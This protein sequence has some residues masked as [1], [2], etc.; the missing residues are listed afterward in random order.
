[1]KVSERVPSRTWVW[2]DR[3][4]FAAGVFLL[5]VLIVAASRANLVADSVDYYV[6]L[7]RLVS[8]EEPPIVRNPHFAEQR[9]PGYSLAA[10]VPFGLL[11]IAVEPWV[12]TEVV[13][14][15]PPA[16]PQGPGSEFR[17][18]PPQ[19]IRFLD[20]PFKD[21][22][23]PGEGSWYRW[24]TALALGLTSYGFLF[25]GLAA[26]ALALRRRHPGFPGYSLVLL[27]VIGSPVFLQEVFVTPLYATLTAFGA[28]A[29][30]ALFFLRGFETRR[31]GDLLAAGL[32]LGLLV[33]ARL[34]TGVLAAAVGIALLVKRE[35]RLLAKLVLG[36]SW[37]FLA[38]GAFNLV[39]FDTPL[40]F[41]LLEG[42]INRLALDGG[43]IFNALIHPA[44]GIL[45]WSPLIILGLAGLVMSRSTPLRML[46]ASSAVLVLLYLVRVPVMAWNVGGG[47]MEI[48][49]LPVTPPSTVEALRELIRSDMNRYLTVLAP[50][51]VL[52]LRDLL[53]RIWAMWRSNSSSET[54]QK[55]RAKSRSASSSSPS[56]GP[57]TPSLRRPLPKLRNS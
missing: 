12:A 38:W 21:F 17:Q 44:S 22:E 43:Y 52:G 24:K 3:A 55:R 54:R 23:V 30:F 13:E 33:L 42:D 48:G 39:L 10:L 47:P 19:A 27:V 28:S 26:G 51:A 46:G 41:A 8:P 2:V 56:P 31:T 16:G 40:H 29:L 14:A 7:Q 35:W 32:F 20:V 5:A 1:V 57:Y 18:I 11:T 45:I 37:A 36:S 49:G 34:E 53:G 9:S 25:L 50:F 15:N 4:L 6:N